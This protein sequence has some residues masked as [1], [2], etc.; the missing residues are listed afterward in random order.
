LHSYAFVTAIAC[1]LSLI[2]LAAPANPS[3][4]NLNPIAQSETKTKPPPKPQPAQPAQDQDEAVRLSSRLVLVPVSASDSAGQPVKG[5][6]VEDLVIEEEGRPQQIVALGEPGKTPVEIALLFDVSGSTNSQFAFEQ[7]AAEKFVRQVLKPGDGVSL[8][9]IGM[10]PKLVRARTTSG[11][12]VING[13]RSIGP[14]KEP[15]AFFDSVVEATHYLDKNADAGSRRVLVIISDGEENFSVHYKLDDALRELEKTDCLFY[16]INPSGGGIRLNTI[17][18][19]GQHSMEAMAAETGGQA[20]NLI[21]L[22][23]LESV[24]HQIAEELQ[25]QYLFGY[26]ATGEGG[27]FKR[28]TVRAPRRP[29]LRIRARQGYYAA[30]P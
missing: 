10:T 17:S 2:S 27:G 16:S 26:Y 3:Q 4:C 1:L 15:T 30:K 12:E 24:F 9:S 14:L 21:K 20:F 29:E 7:Q 8:F 18:L 22:E 19:K 25:A 6:K 11:D 23:D 13:I 5:L 28:I